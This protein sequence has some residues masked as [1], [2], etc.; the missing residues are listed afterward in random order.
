MH[1]IK[2]TTVIATVALLAWGCEKSKSSSESKLN[3]Y[4]TTEQTRA[5]SGSFEPPVTSIARMGLIDSVRKFVVSAELKF[6]AKDV[7]KTTYAIENLTINTGGFVTYTELYSAENYRNVVK[8]SADSSLESIFYTVENN[9]TLRIPKANLDSFLR[10]VGNEVDYFDYR[11][12]KANDVGLDLLAN[13]LKQKRLATYEKSQQQNINKPTNKPEETYYAQEN[14]LDKQMQADE[15]AI[16]KLK[17]EDEVKYSFVSLTI[18]QREAVKRTMAANT[19]NIH[20]YEPGFISRIWNGLAKGWQLFE[21][22]I[23]A[24]ANIWTLIVLAILVF[25]A[26]RRFWA[27]LKNK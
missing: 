12:V 5:D 6:R 23:V 3:N 4:V 19:E 15:A 16:Q 7:V 27:R 10:G 17:T 18:Y 1:L 8:I 20:A 22:L 21:N 2:K 14:L 9:M 25:I 24:L 13:N 11:I 26:Y